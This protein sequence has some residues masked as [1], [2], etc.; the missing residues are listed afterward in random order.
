MKTVNDNSVQA[1][2]STAQQIHVHTCQVLSNDSVNNDYRH[3]ILKAADQILDVQ[4]GQFFHLL[5]P[6]GGGFRPYLRRPMSIYRADRERGE[7]HFL[8]KVQGEGTGAMGQLVAGDD[9][10][11][12]GPLGQGFSIDPS[13]KHL[14]LVARG[15]GLATL[16]PL[17]DVAQQMGCRLTAI[18]SARSPEMLMSTEYFRDK[19]AEVIT[20]TDSVGTSEMAHLKE[21]LVG[22]I[23]LQGIDAFYTCG[24]NRILKMLQ[25][26]CDEYSIPGQIALEQ[27]M[28]C[29]I[30]MCMCCVRQFRKEG[31]IVSERVC[32]EGPVFDLQEAIAW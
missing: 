20:L 32:K 9:F 2:A 25:E 22:I 18:C 6:E 28:A 15:V 8:Y 31:N 14:V 24:S 11:V 5:C 17:A 13:W 12:V 1:L 26:V 7:L 16:A 23:Q 27:Q 29:G 10:N 30:G 4:P 21:L 19:G 3:L